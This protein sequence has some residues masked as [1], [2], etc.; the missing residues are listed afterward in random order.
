MGSEC[1]K[2]IPRRLREP[3]F[4]LRYFVG[5]GLDIGAGEDGLSRYSY[6]FPK[7]KGVRD[8]DVPDGDGQTLEGLAPNSFDFVHSSHSL[9][10]MKDPLQSL[11]RWVEVTK[12]NGHVVVT[13]P[14][15]DLYEQGV[16]PSTWNPDHKNSFTIGKYKSWCPRSVNVI[17]LCQLLRNHAELVRLVR[18]EETFSQYGPRRDQTAGIAECAI[19]FVL[20]KRGP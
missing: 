7:C 6:L 10:H 18:L 2:S 8:W 19:E 9:E 14:D 1:L 15:E 5:L 12:P 13:I 16:W 17:E 11:V 3:A 4:S 20:R